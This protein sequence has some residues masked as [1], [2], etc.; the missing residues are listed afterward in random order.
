M[1]GVVVFFLQ[2]LPFV[3]T[4]TAVRLNIDGPGGAINFVIFQRERII[5]HAVKIKPHC[6]LYS[7]GIRDELGYNRSNRIAHVLF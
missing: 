5:M 1:I 7:V 6:E 4:Q 3:L 2:T